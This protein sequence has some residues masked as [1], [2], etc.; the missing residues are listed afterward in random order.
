MLVIS[1]ILALRLKS[2]NKQINI[3]LILFS[4]FSNLVFWDDKVANELICQ[5]VRANYLVDH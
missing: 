5:E 1:F 4:F 2:K 3:L